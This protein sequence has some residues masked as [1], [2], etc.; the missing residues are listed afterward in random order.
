MEQGLVRPI[1]SGLVAALVGYTSSFAVVL[2]GLRAVGASQAQATVAL[3]ILSFL[4]GLGT[5]WLSW[6]HRMPVLLAWS[7]PGAAVLVTV[8][9]VNGGWAAAIGGFIVCGALIIVTALWPWLG[10]Q[11]GRIPAPVAQ[12]ML[13]G[14]LLALCL[15]PLF[16]LQETPL[17][18]LP[19]IAVWLLLMRRHALWSAPVT[20]AL[21]LAVAV[22]AALRAGESLRPTSVNVPGTIPE[23]TI[24][25]ILGISIPLYLVTMASQNIP[26]IAVM[27]SYGYR[28]PWRSSMLVTGAGTIAAGFG[29]GHA[30]N[31]AAITA[32]I[33]ASPDAHPNP[34]QRWWSAQ[35]AGWVYLLLA[36]IT[37]WLTALVA[38]APA[39]VIESVAGL[40]LITTFSAALASSLGPT[41]SRIPAGLTFVTAASPLALFGLSPAFWALVVGLVAWVWLRPAQLEDSDDKPSAQHK[42]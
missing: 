41:D 8:G 15:Q 5:I 42:R 14:V 34:A 30:L 38:V 23:F 37:P 40:A 33:S 3:V 7:T 12:A 26:G 13:A 9:T 28:V 18:I 32:A 2:T 35:V 10:A 11:V 25:A 1:M 39:G 22:I 29:G 21:G 19:L 6:R 24:A 36:L 27:S 4:L 31:L 17:L 20:F 16:A